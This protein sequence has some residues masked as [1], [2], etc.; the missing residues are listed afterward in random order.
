MG[1]HAWAPNA[2]T[3]VDD[4]GCYRQSPGSSWPVSLTVMQGYTLY[5]FRR[6]GIVSLRTL[7]AV[8]GFT[9]SNYQLQRSPPPCYGTRDRLPEAP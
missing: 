8:F 9:P 1:Q 6:R 4:T 5:D 2:R 7:Y 3:A